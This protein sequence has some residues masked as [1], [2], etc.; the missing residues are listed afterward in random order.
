MPCSCCSY[1]GSRTTSGESSSRYPYDQDDGNVTEK[2]YG[3]YKLGILFSFIIILLLL[4]GCLS[5]FF[6]THDNNLM[7][8]IL[9]IILI[10]IGVI[11]YAYIQW[12][13]RRAMQMR[14]NYQEQ[15][16]NLTRSVQRPMPV[17]PKEVRGGMPKTGT[18]NE[19]SIPAN[20]PRY[21]FI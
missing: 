18:N 2:H 10:L 14:R 4:I 6:L 5:V 1:G 16:M 17:V 13:H 7:L 3:C 20:Q 19:K 9:L 11:T 15:K 8:L 12:Q 21:S